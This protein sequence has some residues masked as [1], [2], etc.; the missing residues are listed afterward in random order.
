M[1]LITISMLMLVMVFVSA[2]TGCQ[3][4]VSSRSSSRQKEC[5]QELERLMSDQPGFEATL[6]DDSFVTSLQLMR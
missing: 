5:R 1:K 2:I 6:C 3:G 4:N